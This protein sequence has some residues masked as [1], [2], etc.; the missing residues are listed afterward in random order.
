MKQA[1]WTCSENMGRQLLTVRLIPA[2]SMRR[3]TRHTWH[4]LYASL[5]GPRESLKEQDCC[6][7]VIYTPVRWAATTYASESDTTTVSE[8]SSQL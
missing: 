7:P 3:L 6:K 2:A 5:T 4:A 1:W 8:A